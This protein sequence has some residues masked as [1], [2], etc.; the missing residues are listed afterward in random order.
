MLLCN[1]LLN[2]FTMKSFQIES[3][4]LRVIDAVQANR[5]N[6]DFLVELKR[7]WIEEKEAARRIAGHANAA[8]GENILWLIG[9]DEKGAEKIIGAELQELSNWYARVESCFDE[10]APRMIPLN[11]PIDRKTIVALLFETERAPFVVKS[12]DGVGKIQREVPWR[13]NTGLRSARRSDLIRILSPLEKLP[14]LEIIDLGIKI[15]AKK[16]YLGQSYDVGDE[17]PKELV[18]NASMYIVGRQGEKVIFPVHRCRVF[19]Q[20]SGYD[21][22]EASKIFLNTNQMVTASN[23]ERSD[24]EII[25]HEAGKINLQA[26]SG[27]QELPYNTGECSVNISIHLHAVNTERPVIIT[28]TLSYHQQQ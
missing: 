9:V 28:K 21:S 15:G 1:L 7:E 10:I 22:V 26:I 24:D 16:T 6:E 11:I 27:I 17:Y 4:A 19:C 8:R 18:V 5:P 3:W 2:N 13:E 12:P 23:I 25:I 20:L 14:N